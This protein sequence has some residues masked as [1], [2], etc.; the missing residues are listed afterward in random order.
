MMRFKLSP[1]LLALAAFA[2]CWVPKAT[3]ACTGSSPQ[4][5]TTPDWA[6]VNT[7]VG[8]ASNGDT[9]SVSA[10]TADWTS[11][12]R[13]NI[14]NK[15]LNIIGAGAGTQQGTIGN[16]SCSNG[17]STITGPPF[18][19]FFTTAPLGG[20]RISGFT[21]HLNG[22]YMILSTLQ[23]FRFDHNCMDNPSWGTGIEFDNTSQTIPGFSGIGGTEGVVDHNILINARLV[24]FGDT[25][26][27]TTSQG[28]NRWAEPLN[29]GTVHAV[30][31]E[32]NTMIQ[33]GT[34]DNN[35]QDDNLGGRT[36]SRF[37][38][39]LDSYFE[40]HSIQ[41]DGERGSRLLEAYDN[42][43]TQ[44]G[45]LVGFVR[46]M[47]FRSGTVMM[48]DNTFNV[49]GSGTWNGAVVDIDNVRTCLEG[50][51]FPI[52]GAC[53]G[54]GNVDGNQSGKDGYLCRDQPG[55][56]TDSS[57]WTTQTPPA[58]AQ[59][60]APYYIFNNLDNSKG[61][62]EVGW[63][64]NSGACSPGQLANLQVQIGNNRDV[65]GPIPASFNG[66][67]GVGRGAL[68]SAPATCTQGVGYW[69]TDQGSW[70]S[71]LAANTSGQLYVCN[72]SNQWIL[73]YTPFI[74]PHPLVSGGGN[75][76]APPQNLQAVIQ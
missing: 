26:S 69:A 33:L 25:T 56:S 23:G 52:Y 65:Y 38:N 9:I 64:Y 20:V 50:H 59:T 19:V 12:G 39:V 62:A 51:S 36:V 48:F 68:A 55:A 13:I 16:Y 1:T 18:D 24:N 67:T 14:Q 61:G 5:T 35:V 4:W 29:E 71:N 73:T 7:C 60:Y 6:S 34:A 70:N 31:V 44:D 3:A 63:E 37:N 28:S 10:G 58:P 21:F 76:P 47:L 72:G 41:G 11:N 2:L 8:S 49:T 15:G 46:T 45:N 74:Y 43:F 32:N 17:P 75:Q 22:S 54:T 27:T 57:L 42:T 53:D 30:Y 66:T 40:F